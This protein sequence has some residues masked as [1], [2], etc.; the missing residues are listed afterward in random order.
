MLFAVN[1]WRMSSR[2]HSV[3]WRP[4][5]EVAC[6]RRSPSGKSGTNLRCRSTLSACHPYVGTPVCGPA[7]LRSIPKV[8][9]VHFPKV[10][11]GDLESNVPA[12]RL[13]VNIV[14]AVKEAGTIGVVVGSVPQVA[15]L[16]EFGR[17]KVRAFRIP[18]VI[19]VSAGLTTGLRVSKCS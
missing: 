13:L 15:P 16:G 14:V 2:R 6:G 5:V 1:L 4:P 19:V 7:A 18:N 11:V 3:A 9:E 10:I 12:R 8:V 17:S